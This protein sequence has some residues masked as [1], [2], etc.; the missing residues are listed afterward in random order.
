MSASV[1]HHYL[2][3][4]SSDQ[5][6]PQCY[7]DGAF[8]ERCFCH[9]LKTN[10]VKY[11]KLYISGKG[12]WR[13]IY[14]NRFLAK[15]LIFEKSPQKWFFGKKKKNSKGK[16]NI[17]GQKS[18]K[19]VKTILTHVSKECFLTFWLIFIFFL[20]LA[21]LKW[22][23][24]QKGFFFLFFWLFVVNMFKNKLKCWKKILAP[25][26]EILAKKW[27]FFWL[28]WSKFSKIRN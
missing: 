15:N 28:F 27:F 4:T 11:I 6:F 1:G 14:L 19:T 5:D 13:I 16:K 8:C 17:F 2:C 18:P 9:N 24:G 26:N 3:H 25:K 23:F 7:K 20:I 12:I 21:F 22:N 10:K